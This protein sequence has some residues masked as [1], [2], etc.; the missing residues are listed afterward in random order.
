MDVLLR[1]VSA[2]VRDHDLIDGKLLAVSEPLLGGLVD[3]VEDGTDLVQI[4]YFYLL[5]TARS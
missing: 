2:V 1:A 5:V 4:I 3:V